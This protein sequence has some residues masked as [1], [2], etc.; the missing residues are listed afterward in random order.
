MDTTLP[1]IVSILEF[2]ST[3][4]VISRSLNGL[5]DSLCFTIFP[6]TD[7][8]NGRSVSISLESSTYLGMLIV[9]LPLSSVPT[10]IVSTAFSTST[11]AF[12]AVTS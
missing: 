1:E 8:S 5:I 7:T 3:S 6:S 4:K 12:D 10:F 11:I 9:I 2:G